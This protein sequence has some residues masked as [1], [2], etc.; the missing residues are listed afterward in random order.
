MVTIGSSV[1]RIVEAPGGSHDS[2]EEVIAARC[3]SSEPI[4]DPDDRLSVGDAPPLEVS[5]TRPG[6]A[7]YTG[8]SSSMV[9]SR[10]SMTLPFIGP[11]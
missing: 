8:C 2:P 1:G 7:A 3:A 10:G 4:D 6:L 9:A 5:W 11:S